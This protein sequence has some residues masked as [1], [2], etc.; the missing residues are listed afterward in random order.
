MTQFMEAELARIRKSLDPS[1]CLPDPWKDE[2]VEDD[3]DESKKVCKKA[4]QDLA[5]QFMRKQKLE[6]LANCLQISKSFNRCLKVKLKIRRRHR[7]TLTDR[8]SLLVAMTTMGKS[9]ELYTTILV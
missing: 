1:E 5:L 4:V 9:A 2:D 8:H 7:L 3:E 6:S